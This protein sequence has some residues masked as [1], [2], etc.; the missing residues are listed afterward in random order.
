M[1]VCVCVCVLVHATD[2]N[3][4]ELGKDL[5]QLRCLCEISSGT[6]P[7][8]PAPPSSWILLFLLCWKS[9][10]PPPHPPRQGFSV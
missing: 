8:H 5:T 6:T 4:Q 10:L 1:S 9:H 2:D 3:F 7:P